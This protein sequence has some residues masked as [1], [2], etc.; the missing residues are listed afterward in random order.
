[1]LISLCIW[2]NIFRDD[3]NHSA[4]RERQKPRLRRL[5]VCREEITNHGKY[6]FDYTAQCSVSESLCPAAR[7]TAQRKCHRCPFGK[8]LNADADRERESGKIRRLCILYCRRTERKADSKPFG[9]VVYHHSKKE[10]RRAFSMRNA[11]PPL[12]LFRN[13]YEARFYRATR[14]IPRR[15]KNRLRRG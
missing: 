11:V 9:N 1:M 10:L 5:Q 15:A 2:N 7:S 6:R 13:V 14:E 12:H 4:G 8:N 3:K